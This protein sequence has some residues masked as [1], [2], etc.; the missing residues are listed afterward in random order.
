MLDLRQIHYFVTLVEHPSVASAAE[1]LG[2]AQPS[3]STSLSKLEKQLGVVLFTRTSRGSELTDAGATLLPRARKLLRQSR[4]FIDLAVSLNDEANRAVRFAITPSLGAALAVPLAETIFNESPDIRLHITEGMSKG[5]IAQ[6]EADTIDF[7]CIY[8][9]VFD[10][11]LMTEPLVTEELFLITAI[12]NWAGEILDDGMAFEEIALD[13]VAALPLVLP[14]NSFGGRTIVEQ[15]LA[16]VGLTPNVVMD[17]DG[18]QHLLQMVSRASAYA[19]LPK[20]AVIEQLREKKL[21]CV[22]IAASPIKRTAY[23]VQKRAHTLSKAESIVRHS[24]RIIL[25]EV[26]E[27]YNL[28]ATVHWHSHA[29]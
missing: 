1:A 16:E 25:Q 21:A 4:D 12:D 23:L 29:L 9:P 19:L 10:S 2:I 15:A 13:R 8:E 7:G 22:R 20:A 5:I 27:R 11:A 6:L 24:L 14:G 26:N 3:L 28:S 18:L 17:I